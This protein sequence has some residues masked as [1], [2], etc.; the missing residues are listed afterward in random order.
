MYVFTYENVADIFTKG[1]LSGQEAAER[2]SVLERRARGVPP[3][4]PPPHGDWVEALLHAKRASAG[5]GNR[6]TEAI[7]L[8]QPMTS[9]KEYYRLSGRGAKHGGHFGAPSDLGGAT[10]LRCAT[11]ARR[12][13][14]WR[15][16]RPTATRS[17]T[18]HQPDARCAN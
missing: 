9:L 5:T 10:H 16:T 1:Y 7:E 14:R 2:W 18:A 4:T 17:Q 3:S 8:N 15:D 13:P 6:L 12:A 11:P